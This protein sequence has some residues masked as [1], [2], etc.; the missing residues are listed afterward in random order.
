[1][2]RCKVATENGYRSRSTTRIT[3]AVRPPDVNALLE[4]LDLHDAI[5]VGFSMGT[6][7]VT[8]YL[9]RYGSACVSN[10]A[11]L[12]AMPPLLL[13]RD[14]KPAGVGGQVFEDISAAIVKD[15]PEA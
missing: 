9:D 2:P 14:D 13:K 8:R 6:G 4:H 1:M 5:R 11:L 3:A 12:G 15:R 10:A 7:E